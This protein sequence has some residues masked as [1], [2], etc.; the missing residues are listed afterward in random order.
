MV[1]YKQGLF[2][3]GHQKGKKLT[4]KDSST[5]SALCPLFSD[6][7]VAYDWG[8]LINGCPVGNLP[9]AVFNRWL[10]IMGELLINGRFTLNAI[11]SHLLL[12]QVENFR[13][14]I[15]SMKFIAYLHLFFLYFGQFFLITS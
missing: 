8:L 13:G 4:S 5:P 14:K 15:H 2:I 1:A 6:Q 9:K 10:L 11:Q 12:W 7:G 3:N